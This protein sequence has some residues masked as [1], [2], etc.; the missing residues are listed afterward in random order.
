MGILDFLFP[1]VCV[2]CENWGSYL[3]ENCVNGL[4][5]ARQVCPMCGKGS[6]CGMVHIRCRKKLG[7]DGLIRVVSYDGLMRKLVAKIKYRLVRDM[8][9]TVVDTVISMGDFAP[10]DQ[11]VWLVVPVPLH[12]ERKRWRGFNQSEEIGRRIATSFGWEYGD[13]LVRIKNTKP[14]VSMKGKEERLKNVRG[15]FEI[16]SKFKITNDKQIANKNVLLVDDVWTTGATMRE[17]A[18]VLKKAG[19]KKVWGLVVA[20]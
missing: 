8:V 5:S 4:R 14:Q 7:M 9:D 17:C 3:C 20:G 2:G 12:I 18:K 13:V 19:V 10:I 6:V 1:K 15:A 11:D 16:N